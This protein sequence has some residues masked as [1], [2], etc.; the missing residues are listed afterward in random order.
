MYLRGS[1]LNCTVSDALI[2]T[3]TIVF[4]NK[5]VITLQ[6]LIW[7]LGYL[8]AVTHK[9]VCRVRLCVCVCLERVYM[10]ILTA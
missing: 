5:S 1:V 10:C 6:C 7:P 3:T 2:M 9:L 8:V 4:V